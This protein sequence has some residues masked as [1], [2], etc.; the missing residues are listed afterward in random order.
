LII[1]KGNVSKAVLL[2]PPAEVHTTTA[3]AWL[4]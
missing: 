1:S 2:A 3:P 4:G